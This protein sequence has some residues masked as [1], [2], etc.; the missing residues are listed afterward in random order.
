MIRHIP[1]LCEAG[2]D[3]LKI[4]GRMKSEYYAAVTAN[5]YR[6]ALD[7]Y[8]AS[9]ENYVFDERLRAKSSRFPT[10]NTAPVSFSGL[11]RKTRMCALRS[12]IYATKHILP[13]R[14][15]GT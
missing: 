8:A 1:E 12:I 4:E 14:K 15:A 7:S 9:P 13:W 6:I 10:A 11:R 3:S 5:A 2:I